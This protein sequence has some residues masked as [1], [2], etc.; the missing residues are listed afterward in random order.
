MISISTTVKYAGEVPEMAT[1]MLAVVLVATWISGSNLDLAAL[2][3]CFVRSWAAGSRNGWVSG[4]GCVSKEGGKR[5]KYSKCQ[6]VKLFIVFS[7]YGYALA[8]RGGS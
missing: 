3:V 2:R 6:D 1:T 5:G 4:S 8:Y 7:L